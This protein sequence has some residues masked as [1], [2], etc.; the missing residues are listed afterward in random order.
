MTE[1]F[2]QRFTKLRKQK[3]LTQEEI[4][5]RVNIS[6][7]AVSKWENDI[8]MPDISILSDIADI[9]GVTLDELLGRRSQHSVTM[10]DEETKKDLNKMA[11]KIKILSS[12]GDKVN[13]NIPIS[14]L[15]VCIQS[16]IDMPQINGN[17]KLAN[18]DFKQIYSLIEQGVIGELVSVESADGDYISIIVE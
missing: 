7:Q 6:A 14:L 3:G 5:Y 1:T 16:G 9:L 2:G 10:L 4:A 8:S 15:Q 13:V 12:D 18:I 11:L 17:D